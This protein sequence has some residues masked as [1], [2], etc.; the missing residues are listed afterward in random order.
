MTESS[1]NLELFTGTNL[2]DVQPTG[3]VWRD[4]KTDPATVPVP[5]QTIIMKI[6]GPYTEKDRKLWVF[7]LHAVFHELGEKPIHSLP[8]KD[9]NGVFRELG[10]EHDTRWLWESAKRLARTVVE[11][12]NTFDDDRFEQGVAAI[13]GANISKNAISSGILNFFF[14]PNLIPILKQPNRFARLRVRFLLQLSGKYAVTLYEILEGF[15]NRKDKRCEVEI[16]DL[17]Q[18]LKVP[19]NSYKNWKDFKKWVLEPAVKQINEDSEGAGFTVS[20]TAERK[21]RFYHKLIFNL[22]QTTSRRQK[23]HKIK[24]IA[25]NKQ[26]LKSARLYNRPVLL[27]SVID[28]IRIETDCPLDMKLVETQFWEYWEKQGCP[29]FKNP[30]HVVFTGFVRKKIKQYQQHGRI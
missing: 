11:W 9:I 23:D 12:E 25:I 28:E 29:V 26:A 1:E 3:S 2:R 8:I 24:R 19:E 5:L 6:E 13:F 21:G 14:P 7:L 15:A 17:K 16:D 20:Y 27:P 18:W 4:S 22:E 30:I 10:G